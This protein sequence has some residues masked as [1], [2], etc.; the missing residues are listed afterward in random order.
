ME[1]GKGLSKM[2]I[3]GGCRQRRS[4]I[5][6]SSDKTYSIA[7][8]EFPTQI[9][10]DMAKTHVLFRHYG[11]K[12][13]IPSIQVIHQAQNMDLKLLTR[14]IRAYL[15]LFPGSSG[16]PGRSAQQLAKC[17]LSNTAPLA[18]RDIVL[19]SMLVIIGAGT[20]SAEDAC[21]YWQSLVI[22]SHK[23]S[24]NKGYKGVT[25]FEAFLSMIFKS[26]PGAYKNGSREIHRYN[27]KYI[28]PDY[29][30]FLPVIIR[31]IGNL[32]MN[33]SIRTCDHY[34]HALRDVFQIWT[35]RNQAALINL[36]NV[37][38]F[39]NKYRRHIIPWCYPVKFLLEA[40]NICRFSG[41][42]NPPGLKAIIDQAISINHK[43]GWNMH[44]LVLDALSVSTKITGIEMIKLLQ[45]ALVSR[46][47]FP[48]YELIIELWKAGNV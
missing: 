6:D 19:R 27:R 15:S 21:K 38:V 26:F 7:L 18:A 24:I 5:L 43:T 36:I 17:Y 29:R 33:S 11:T 10:L 2:I 13:I 3:S 47:I 37:I 35:P 25:Y 41:L 8:S 14:E 12:T 40:R 44:S 39:T 28:I 48:S 31:T 23:W 4:V 45:N 34:I 1:T 16:N 42:F 20:I 9:A 32:P 22:A 30:S 46:G